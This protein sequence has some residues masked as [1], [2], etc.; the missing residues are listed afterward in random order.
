MRAVLPSSGRQRNEVLTEFLLTL[1]LSCF[2]VKFCCVPNQISR[3]RARVRACV[4]ACVSVRVC[5]CVCVCAC[6]R[7][8]VC[9]RVPGGSAEGIGS[10]IQQTAARWLVYIGLTCTGCRE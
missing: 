7:L 2:N 1:N 6:V 5:V 8:C 9:V 3:A 4:R 10:L